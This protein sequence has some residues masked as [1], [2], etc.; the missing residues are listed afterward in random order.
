MHLEWCAC[1]GS[2]TTGGFVHNYNCQ[3][4]P[5]VP[6]AKKPHKCPVCD[7]TGLVSRPPY[8]AGD[9]DSWTDSQTE[10]YQCKACGDSGIIWG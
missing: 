8:V 9:V 2:M 7:G 10:P 3:Y 6:K 1:G 5:W 4:G